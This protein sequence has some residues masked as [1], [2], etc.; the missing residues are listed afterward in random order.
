MKKALG[1]LGALVLVFGMAGYAGAYSASYSDV[2]TPASPIWDPP[3]DDGVFAY[4]TYD[5]TGDIDAPHLM[6]IIT[7]D[8]DTM[9]YLYQDSFNASAPYTNLLDYA[10]GD[11]GI[12]AALT[13]G[14]DYFLVTTS[15]APF[16]TGSFTAQISVIP[17]PASALLL[18]S[19][20]IP[21]IR[22]RRK[23]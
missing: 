21:L 22:L 17:I 10:G 9:I 1:I 12:G 5:F 4:H 8:F 6:E 20:L 23:S 16:T 13:A 2:L 3:H 18:G 14:T 11:I 15:T 19:G 7:A